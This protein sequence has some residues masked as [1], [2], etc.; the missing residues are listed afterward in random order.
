MDIKASPLQV[1]PTDFAWS[2]YENLRGWIAQ[3]DRKASTVLALESALIAAAA[4]FGDLASSVGAL[5]GWRLVIVYVGVAVMM[6]GAALSGA[7]VKPRLGRMGSPGWRKGVG[8]PS[9]TGHIYF[10]DLRNQEAAALAL[11]L[12]EATPEAATLEL[13]QQIIVMSQIAWRKHRLLQ[14]SIT[15]AAIGF[16]T[17]VVGAMPAT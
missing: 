15:L 13:A 9:K 11:W 10:G 8:T 1:E 14:S 5:A 6:V 3:A 12:L 16:A 4:L 2:I 7:A 17:I